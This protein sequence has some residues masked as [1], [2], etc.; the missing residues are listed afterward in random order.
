M[1]A[2]IK[3]LVRRVW[4]RHPPSAAVAAEAPRDDVI[5]YAAPPQYPGLDSIPDREFYRPS[6]HGDSLFSPWENRA[7]QRGYG[8]FDTYVQLAREV[9]TA[10]GAERLYTLFTLARQCLNLP[11]DFLE[12]GVWKGGTAAMLAKL[13]RE[14]SPHARELHLFDT[15]T[16]M[17]PTHEADTYYKGGEFA[18]T[19][20]EKVRAAVNAEFV[21]FH[22]GRV[23]ETFGE[24]GELSLAFAHIDLD[25]YQSIRDATAFVY[26]RLAVGGVMLFDDYAWSTCPGARRAVDEF[27]ADRRM[28]PLVLSNGQAVVF[29][30]RQ[31]A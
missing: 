6:E 9:G 31:E 28:C 8:D 22:P 14:Q 1:E 16:G 7:N 20:L 24:C 18:D 3:R 5:S 23:P 30:A 15:F 2:H 10:V 25:V 26:P 21:R 27:F 19:S 11:G 12:A 17:P 29:K 13:I 4:I